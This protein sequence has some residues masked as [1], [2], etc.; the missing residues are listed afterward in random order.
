MMLGLADVAFVGSLSASS[1]DVNAQAYITEVER[2]DGQPLET[3]VKNA[4]NA[5]VVGCKADGIWNA[6]KASCILAGARTLSGALVPLVGAAPTNNNFVSG[7]Y[8]RKTGLLGNGSS[9][10]LDTNTPSNITALN[11]VHLSVY[12]QTNTVPNSSVALNFYAGVLSGCGT[13]LGGGGGNENTWVAH[14]TTSLVPIFNNSTSTGFFAVQRGN[15]SNYDR[16]IGG[17]TT[18]VIRPASTTPPGSGTVHVFARNG[19]F[20][21]PARIAFYSYGESLNL[22]LLDA[23]VTT[24]I[25]AFAA[26]IP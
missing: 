4:I 6:I 12:T 16:R 21:C 23:R 25:N 3:A 9:K 15:S 18:N 17:I 14:D 8:N 22:A 5:F 7:D 20:L 2:I 11:N 19:M 10:Y 26:A 1:Y 13:N 24:L